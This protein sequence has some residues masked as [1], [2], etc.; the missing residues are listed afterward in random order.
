MML[1]AIGSHI[2]VGE[3][4]LSGS[5]DE[6][7]APDRLKAVSAN[8]V[9]AEVLIA[10][11]STGV[12]VER[13]GLLR[14]GGVSGCVFLPRTFDAIGPNEAFASGAQRLASWSSVSADARLLVQ[15]VVRGAEAATVEVR[16]DELRL[17]GLQSD[18]VRLEPVG[19]EVFERWEGMFLGVS[20]NGPEGLADS[21]AISRG[22]GEF[23][24]DLGLDGGVLIFEPNEWPLAGLVDPG[25]GAWAL[26]AEVSGSEGIECE[27]PIAASVVDMTVVPRLSSIRAVRAG[28][29]GNV[30]AGQWAIDE[31]ISGVKDDVGRSSES[32]YLAASS[33]VGGDG[34]GHAPFFLLCVADN[35]LGDGGEPF[36]RVTLMRLWAHGGEADAVSV[37][38]PGA[39]LAFPSILGPSPFAGEEQAGAVRLLSGAGS[40]FFEANG[41]V[42]FRFDLEGELSLRHANSPFD[43]TAFGGEGPSLCGDAD[44][45]I[46]AGRGGL[47]V[48]SLLDLSS[49]TSGALAVPADTLRA[50]GHRTALLSWLLR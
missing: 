38:V 21:M 22:G 28:P 33:G 40:D 49:A 14:L 4:Y 29:S 47:W 18:S 19:L 12:D 10:V 6:W 35:R 32:V 34:S 17:G 15:S 46:S 25:G 8:A 27:F 37:D 48:L 44:V 7:L 39:V 13:L 24:L 3:I 43:G 9:D 16:Q 11:R 50:S 2:Q 36:S 5:A 26:L 42:F 23:C 45:L 41:V 31:L 30:I 1:D 20:V